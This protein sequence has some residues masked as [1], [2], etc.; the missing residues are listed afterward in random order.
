VFLLLTPFISGVESE[1]AALAEGLQVPVFGPYTLFPEEILALNR[2]TFY[3][4]TGPREQGRALVIFSREKLES[5]EHKAAV[6]YPDGKFPEDVPEAIGEQALMQG[7]AVEKLKYKGPFD[8][9]KTASGMS[10]AGV[11]ALFWLGSWKDLK[12]L[13][14]EADKIDWTPFI[15][16]SAAQAGREIFD[17]PVRFGDRVFLAY[18]VLPSDQTDAGMRELGAFAKKHHIAG[19]HFAAR[20]SAYAT[21]KVLLEGLKRAGKDLSREKLVST[22]DKFYEFETG[23]TQ[24]I[25]YSPNR[26]IG[27]LG[28]HIVGVDLQN[29]SFVP[30]GKWISL[31]EK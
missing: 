14:D 4:L 23:L 15:F 1:L 3:L 2:F 29:R 22:M 7:W 5:G 11:D 13:M 26:R 17:I 16:L 19:S 18:P 25:T 31:E 9:R 24:P 10:A 8:A 6:I 28:A 12:S 21:C 20:I 30:V 27:A